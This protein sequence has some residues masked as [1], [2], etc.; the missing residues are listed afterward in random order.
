MSL[1]KT[2]LVEAFRK[3]MDGE[4]LPLLS[5]DEFFGNNAEEESIAPNQWGFGRPTL[6]EIWGN[7]RKVEERED[8]KW[9]RVALHPDTEVGERDGGIVYEIA[10][11]F[12]A[13]CT[14]AKPSDIEQTANCTQL[15]SDGVTSSFQ[16]KWYSE[17]PAVPDGYRVL[18]LWWD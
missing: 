3:R 11:D 5:L 8:V 16:P 6:M 7:L 15:C 4:R 10:G 14:T 2:I 18:S 9:V 17:I 12:I 13:I 1:D